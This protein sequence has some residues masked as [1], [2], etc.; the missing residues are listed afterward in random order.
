[1]TD[2]SPHTVARSFEGIIVWLV[3]MGWHIAIFGGDRRA[4][5]GEEIESRWVGGKKSVLRESGF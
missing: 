4:L 1:M 3:D 2:F 5:L